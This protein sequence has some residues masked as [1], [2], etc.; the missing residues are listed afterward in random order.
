MAKGLFMG[1]WRR[2]AQEA[3]IEVK[4]LFADDASLERGAAWA[5]SVI[6]DADLDPHDQ[7]V[8]SIKALREADPRLSLGA[9][10]FLMDLAAGKR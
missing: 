7:P 3:E 6:Q 5:I 8:R 9:A 10:R 1:G 4:G 2:P